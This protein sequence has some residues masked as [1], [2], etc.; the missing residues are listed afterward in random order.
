MQQIHSNL[1][2]L[3]PKPFDRDYEI[4]HLYQAG[5]TFEFLQQTISSI[6]SCSEI[7]GTTK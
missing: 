7:M 1:K 6:C 3:V 4:I 5:L 2:L